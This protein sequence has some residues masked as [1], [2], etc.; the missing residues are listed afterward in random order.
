MAVINLSIL[1]F[2]K[3]FPEASDKHRLQMLIHFR[4]PLM[5]ATMSTTGPLLSDQPAPPVTPDVRPAP[6]V[7]LDAGHGLP[8]HSDVTLAR[9]VFPHQPQRPGDQRQVTPT[10]ALVLRIISR[11]PL[12]HSL[13]VE[14]VLDLDD[15]Y[16]ITI[17]KKQVGA[18]RVN[19]TDRMKKRK[20][21]H[22]C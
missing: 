10:P 11:Q 17:M 1:V 8:V 13:L 19:S 15:G 18:K 7:T 2:G 14:A 4:G 3:I 12:Q 16:N 21:V 9:A 20:L 5:F 6:P 22:L